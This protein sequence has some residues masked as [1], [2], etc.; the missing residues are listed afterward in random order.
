MAQQEAPDQ[1]DSASAEASDKPG[2]ANIERTFLK[3]M[4][5]KNLLSLAGV[6]TGGAALYLTLIQ[7]EAV[8]QQTAAA[9]WPYIQF[10]IADTD[11]GDAAR[12]A[13]NFRNVGV[14]PAKLRTAQ[15]QIDGQPAMSW[16]DVTQRLSDESLKLGVH[17]G[18]SAISGRV[19]SPGESSVAFETRHRPLV[20]GLQQAV[21]SGRVALA[22]CYCSI[23]DE[24]WLVTTSNNGREPDHPQVDQCPDY[25]AATF[26]D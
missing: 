17:F 9:A 2:L 18:R 1:P 5:W 3:M 13:L 19:L 14:G 20:L 21:Y 26:R 8:R 10:S 7:A 16:V 12:F 24:C 25:G 11:D 4:F 6:F 15:L 23:F 22:Y